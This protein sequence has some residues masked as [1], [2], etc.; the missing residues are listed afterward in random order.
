M[1]A[2]PAAFFQDDRLPKQRAAR[3]G[4]DPLANVLSN[5]APQQAQAA[6]KAY[7]LAQA[8]RG[9]EITPE[10]A[11]AWDEIYTKRDIVINAKH[12]LA[13]I[14]AATL[15]A[16]N[17]ARTTLAEGNGLFG[18]MWR[19]AQ[20]FG[21]IASAYV[22]GPISGLAALGVAPLEAANLIKQGTTEEV[23]QAVDMLPKMLMNDPAGVVIPDS[24]GLHTTSLESQGREVFQKNHPYLATG[25]QVL[26]YAAPFVSL[27]LTGTRA[28]GQFIRRDGGALRKMVGGSIYG[29][30]H[31]SHTALAPVTSIVD[32]YVYGGLYADQVSLAFARHAARRA[33]KAGT[34]EFTAAQVRGLSFKGEEAAAEVHAIREQLMSGTEWWLELAARN[35]ARSGAFVTSSLGEG[36]GDFVR[37][38]PFI[39]SFIPEGV[40]GDFIVD[41]GFG[42]VLEGAAAWYQLSKLAKQGRGPLGRMAADVL[43]DSTSMVPYAGPDNVRYTLSEGHG[44]VVESGTRAGI[45]ALHDLQRVGVDVDFIFRGGAVAGPVRVNANRMKA[46]PKPWTLV[47]HPKGRSFG[48]PPTDFGVRLG[49]ETEDLL[50]RVNLAIKQGR[51]KNPVEFAAALQNRLRKVAEAGG[52]PKANELALSFDPV[53]LE[54]NL[55]TRTVVNYDDL[56]REATGAGRIK[57]LQEGPVAAR[58]RREAGNS[59]TVEISPT[60]SYGPHSVQDMGRW[61]ELPP[62]TQQA[63]GVSAR[64]GGPRLDRLRKTMDN[65]AGVDTPLDRVPEPLRDIL[66]EA[67]DF[68]LVQLMTPNNSRKGA[69]WLVGNRLDENGWRRPSFGPEGLSQFDN[70]GRPDWAAR[71][72]NARW[73]DLAA[74]PAMPAR[75]PKQLDLLAGA[76]KAETGGIKPKSTPSIKSTKPVGAVGATKPK[77]PPP[78][79]IPEPKTPRQKVR[80]AV[81]RAQS[82]AEESA[83]TIIKSAVGTTEKKARAIVTGKPQTAAIG[84]W[85]ALPES[86]KSKLSNEEILALVRMQ[87]ENLS[88]Q[89]GWSKVERAAAGAGMRRDLAKLLQGVREGAAKKEVGRILVPDDK[90]TSISGGHRT[91]LTG[92]QRLQKAKKLSAGEVELMKH[93]FKDVPGQTL[94]KLEINPTGVPIGGGLASHGAR[95]DLKTGNFIR[96]IIKMSKKLFTANE[97]RELVKKL[98]LQAREI[99]MSAD[100]LGNAML[101][102]K[103]AIQGIRRNPVASFMHEFGHHGW[104]AVL[105]TAERLEIQRVFDAYPHA[106]RLDMF[107]PKAASAEVT[108]KMKASMVATL[109]EQPGH[110]AG[111]VH[112]FFA[113]TF[114]DWVMYKTSL[115]PA[116]ES[117]FRRLYRRLAVAMKKFFNPEFRREGQYRQVQKDLR[118]YFEAIMSRKPVQPVPRQPLKG[119]VTQTQFNMAPK[120]KEPKSFRTFRGRLREVRKLYDVG[121]DMKGWYGGRDAGFI[122]QAFGDDADLFI[123][124]VAATSKGN[125]VDGGLTQAIN[126]YKKWKG[127]QSVNTI[128]TAV[129]KGS[130]GLAKNEVNAI[131][132]GQR[133]DGEKIANFREALQLNNDA[134]VVDRWMMRA[135]GSQKIAPNAKEYKEIARLIRREAAEIG[136]TPIEYQAAVWTG[137]KRKMEGAG[138]KVEEFNTTVRKKLANYQLDLF[139]T[140]PMSEVLARVNMN[141]TTANVVEMKAKFSISESPQTLFKEVA[142]QLPDGTILTPNIGDA[143]IHGALYEYLPGKV[144]PMDVVDGF[145]DHKGK[146]YNRKEAF[147]LAGDR[148]KSESFASSLD[149]AE[150]YTLASDKLLPE[151]KGGITGVIATEAKKKKK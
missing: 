38:R 71:E 135:F 93:M 68:G 126:V 95:I 59:L 118:P 4:N 102:H 48:S 50:T 143:P 11:A 123:Q 64:R 56:V 44:V 148:A 97:T 103:K 2:E 107:I 1:S 83:T 23:M 88:T 24:F 42:A 74:G 20:E 80:Q 120:K 145:V 7:Q 151:R 67:D 69:E 142:V 87:L 54:I 134:V 77:A 18:G 105:T 9:T 15:R 30:S 130:V 116:V 27:G 35:T 76:T 149:L 109:G 79:P 33:T 26:G 133:W 90:F 122:T 96:G 104:H 19:A 72:L 25:A 114:S 92:L 141:P 75:A 121:E 139:E 73:A 53:S 61:W 63:G 119:G 113:E 150:S 129:G 8:G 39:G 65:Y 100:E 60:H 78:K 47:P 110:Y 6:L 40:I 28:L 137:I 147:A 89:L 84:L 125:S 13:R 131:L 146:F 36:V 94:M 140:D 57:L 52:V 115:D 108:A 106:S 138:T 70:A 49:K 66:A 98:S 91:F 34:R 58:L 86:V 43:E 144:N 16:S 112:E 17:E 85:K 45:D 46:L 81:G 136:V 32:R 51:V 10:G 132:T 31:L 14:E 99:G 128:I 101:T 21:E 22:T 111:N 5:L 117:V 3:Y 127:G 55:T 124:L 12:N 41:F 82:P 62:H 37:E 29:S